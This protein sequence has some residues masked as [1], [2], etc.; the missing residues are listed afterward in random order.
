MASPSLREIKIIYTINDEKYT[1]VIGNKTITTYFKGKYRHVWTDGKFN[2]YL[3]YD[4]FKYV[5]DTEKWDQYFEVR[6]DVLNNFKV[7]KRNISSLKSNMTPDEVK[8]FIMSME[9]KYGHILKN[10]LILIMISRRRRGYLPKELWDYIKINFIRA[11]IIK[12]Y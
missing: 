2:Y 4:N 9:Y 1:F 8:I 7:N 12:N 3:T 11:K 6:Y 10:L 5:N